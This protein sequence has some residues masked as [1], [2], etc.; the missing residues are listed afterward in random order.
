MHGIVLAC[1]NTQLPLITQR[2]GVQVVPARPGKDH[3]DQHLDA[4][5]LVVAGT[6]A[7][8][9]AVA[10]R[11]LRKEKLGS[12]A[13]GYVPVAESAVAALWGLSTDPGRALDIALNGDV[14]PVPLVRDDVGGVLMGRGVLSPV[15]GVG[16]SDADNV[17][18]GQ[19]SRVECTPDPEGGLGL[20][21]RIVNKRLFGSKVRE[22]RPR[23]FQL[24]CL[25]TTAVLDG[26][27]HPRPV[28]KWTWYRHTEDLRL[29]RGV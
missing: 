22:S 23:A 29:V 20:V 21:I 7:D 19:A 9:A 4:G 3:V 1:G 27:R 16:Y 18:R 2:D 28:D 6:D 12:V 24:G 15:R 11:L 5:R 17:L 14:D 26:H 8:L 10:L 13:L 25:P